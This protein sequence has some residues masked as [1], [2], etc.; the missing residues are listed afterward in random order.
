MAINL[1]FFNKATKNCTKAF[2]TL[3]V[4]LKNFD[5]S[6]IILFDDLFTFS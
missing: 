3:P 1:I 4:P 2:N 5:M 6:V